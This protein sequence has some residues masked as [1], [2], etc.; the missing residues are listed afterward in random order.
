MPKIDYTGKE[1]SGTRLEMVDV[2]NRI[3]RE[4]AADGYNLTLRQ[5]YYQ[6]VAND[7]FPDDRCYSQTGAGKWV[8]A[9]DGTKNA[10]PNYKWLG[11]I[12]NDARMSGY[13]DWNN[14]VDRTREEAGGTGSMTDPSQVINPNYYWTDK[15]EGQEYYVEV[16]VE[17]EALQQVASRGSRNHEVTYFCCRGYVSQ[18]AQ[19]RA[20]RRMEDAILDGKKVRIIHL[21]DHDPSGIDMTRDI[22]ERLAVFIAQ[23]LGRC[24]E[25]GGVYSEAWQAEEDLDEDFAVERIAL[26]MDQIRRY[27]PPPNP[28]KLTDSRGS[29]YV[30]RFGNESWEL[31]A[32]TPR[33]LVPLIE[34]AVSQYVDH[35]LF[36]ERVERE[37]EE[38]EILAAA[39]ERWP[40]VKALLTS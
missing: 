35:E 4:F 25:P 28:A 39:K 20:A 30:E 23:D 19:W 9:V 17:K 1:M 8:K 13:I 32:L 34:D 7:L 15:W 3:A 24:G 40:E 33:V 21:G 37:N 10:E 12:I 26:N 16:W 14:L 27:N 6:F 22:R 38:R 5:L 36:D 11:D 31:D 2:A 18:S 29:G